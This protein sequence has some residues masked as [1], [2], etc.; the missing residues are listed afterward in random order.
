LK[1][2]CTSP[3]ACLQELTAQQGEDTG[4]IRAPLAT[5]LREAGLPIP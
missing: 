4:T 3:H 5:L 2:G 1:V